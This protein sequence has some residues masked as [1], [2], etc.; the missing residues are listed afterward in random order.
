MADFN[1]A[2]YKGVWVFAEQ[3]NGVMHNVAFELLGKGRELAG[4]LKTELA[5]VLIGKDIKPL[6]QEL[7]AAGADKVYVVDNPALAH[8]NDEVYSSVLRD[9]AAE[10]KPEIILAG[11]T[12]V[13]RA[14]FP[15]VSILLNAGLTADCT[16]F[17]LDLAE[18]NLFQIR[19]AFG[20]SLM[21][22]I[23]T[24]ERR[25]QMATARYKVFKA[26]EKDASR[27]GEII[28]PKINDDS[29]KSISQFVEFIEEVE[30]TVNLS[31][32]DIIVSGGRGMGSG[33]NFRLIKELAESL[34]GAV[35]ASR[36]AVD[37]GWI[38]Y[39]HQVGQTGKTV[40]PKLYIACGISGAV[41]HLAG[42]QSS[43]II[44]AINKD[45][46]APIFGVAKFGIVGDIFSVVPAIIER[47]K[48]R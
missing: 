41:Q 11:A 28:E 23:I 36:A 30:T 45:P 35:G 22:K 6:A 40:S 17:E 42:M 10:Y 5:A 15:R 4:E 13:G 9:I 43:D 25:P 32:A 24:P 20:G 48:K 29:F 12:S 18:R 1:K 7:I 19:P 21:A 16:A 27:T 46:E 3:R 8:F 2:D 44:V 34:G 39:S 14:F 38:Q 33:D 26:L 37:S 47:M 31:E